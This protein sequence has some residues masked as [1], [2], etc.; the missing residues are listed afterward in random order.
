MPVGRTNRR[1]FIAVLGSAAAWPVVTRAQHP[2]TLPIIG[3][4][5]SA[6]QGPTEYQVTAF[7]EGLKEAGYVEGQNVAIEYRWANGRYD[8]LPALASELVNKQIGVI[9]AV[10]PVSAMAAKKAAPNTPIVFVT[11]VDPVGL[12][13]VA[14]LNRPGGYLTGINF[15]IAD[16]PGKSLG[17]TL[18]VIPSI[19]SLAPS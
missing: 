8:Q 7:R 6:S 12:G 16:L 15:N 1:T 14:S 19:N 5:S 9:V 10:A 17:I 18:Q 13:L 2:A 4:L 3:F 11:G